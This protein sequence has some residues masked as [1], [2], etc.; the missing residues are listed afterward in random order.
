MTEDEI[1]KQLAEP[2]LKRL[3]ELEE[4]SGE[5]LL[6]IPTVKFARGNLNGPIEL[7]EFTIDDDLLDK[8]EEYIQSEIEMLHKPTMLH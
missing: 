7:D 8:L 6:E 2:I 1:I 3:Q 4:Q 5:N